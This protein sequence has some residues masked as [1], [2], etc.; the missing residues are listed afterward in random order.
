[1]RCSRLATL[2]N[3]TLGVS[4]LLETLL[5]AGSIVLCLEYHLLLGAS[6][7]ARRIIL[8]LEYYFSLGVLYVARSKFSLGG[9]SLSVFDFLRRAASRTVRLARHAAFVLFLCVSF[10]NFSRK[11]AFSRRII[12]GFLLIGAKTHGC[13]CRFWVKYALFGVA[14]VSRE[15]M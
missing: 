8:C 11:L 13:V 10:M 14:R 4:S 1:M 7:V 9:S 3:S 5:V 12:G 2:L 15:R 6:V